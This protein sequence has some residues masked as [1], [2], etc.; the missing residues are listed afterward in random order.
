MKVA[1]FAGY[2]GAGKTTLV[3]KL[4]P[5]LKARGLARVGRQARAPP[6]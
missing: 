5:A 3:E 2:S 4:I 6:L 1:G